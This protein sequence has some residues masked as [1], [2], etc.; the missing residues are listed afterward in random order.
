MLFGCDITSEV[1][2]GDVSRPLE[3]RVDVLMIYCFVES[4]L[5]FTSSSHIILFLGHIGKS[6]YFVW[7][8]WNLRSG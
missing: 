3:S 5:S 4:D 6:V 1:F 2:T 8:F 7:K